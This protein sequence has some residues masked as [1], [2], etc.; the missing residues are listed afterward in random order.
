MSA[1]SRASSVSASLPARVR[2]T[3]SWRRVFPYLVI[4]PCDPAKRPRADEMRPG[5]PMPV[6]IILLEA[7]R[8]L[9]LLVS[10]HRAAWSQVVW[11]TQS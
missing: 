11:V 8:V 5:R 10:H 4:V 2:S 6:T 1:R 9:G 3:E 7:A